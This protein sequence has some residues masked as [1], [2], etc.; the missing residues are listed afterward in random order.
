MTSLEKLQ[1]QFREVT[2]E[3][4]KPGAL[5]ITTLTPH[6]GLILNNNKNPRKKRLVVIGVDKNSEKVYGSVLVN[7]HLSPMSEYSAEHLAAQ[8]ELS[9]DVYPSFLRYNSYIDCGELF[10]IDID[11]LLSGEYHGELTEEDKQAVWDILETTDTLTTKQKK[12]Y[13]IKRR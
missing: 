9:S 5:L 8:Y 1:L 6:D 3:K 13:N 10:E 2:K 4:L 11:K 7:T 12:K